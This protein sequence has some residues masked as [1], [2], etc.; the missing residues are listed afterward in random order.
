MPKDVQAGTPAPKQ[1]P[2]VPAGRI[3]WRAEDGGAGVRLAQLRLRLE[4]N[5]ARL[6]DS[7]GDS[8]DKFPDALVLGQ[9]SRRITCVNDRLARTGTL[10]EAARKR[11][12]AE[13][14][15]AHRVAKTRA[16]TTGTGVLAS[17]FQLTREAWSFLVVGEVAYLCSILSGYLT[18]MMAQALGWYDSSI[19]PISQFIWDNLLDLVTG[20]TGVFVIGWMIGR[21]VQTTTRGRGRGRELAHS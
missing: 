14:P 16:A 7:G 9:G 10:E 5:S 4:Q 20:A 17:A 12:G 19:E 3:Q 11:R 13:I 8:I 2:I 6:R 18:L 21:V 15:Q 1:K